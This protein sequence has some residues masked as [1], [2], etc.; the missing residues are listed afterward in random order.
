MALDS[1]NGCGRLSSLSALFPLAAALAAAPQVQRLH[2][3]D[4]MLDVHKRLRLLSGEA[5]PLKHVAD[6][7]ASKVK[8]RAAQEPD[9][10]GVVLL[11]RH[12]H[13]STGALLYIHM[14]LLFG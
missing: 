12:P 9:R 13:P 1:T 2:F 11:S 6:D 3:H 14:V 4:F 5:D 10:Q 7:I 8:V